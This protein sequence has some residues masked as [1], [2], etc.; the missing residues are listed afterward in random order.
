MC[1][2]FTTY[3]WKGLDEGCNVALELASIEGSL[4]KLW[5][6]KVAKVSIS[7]IS[8]LPTWEFRDKMAFGCMLLG[9]A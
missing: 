8:G 4:K 9:Q 3:R 1:R 2:W 7:K 5:A 6:F